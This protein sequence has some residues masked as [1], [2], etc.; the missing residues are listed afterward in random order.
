MDVT[1][2]LEAGM[3]MNLFTIYRNRIRWSLT[4]CALL[5][6][7]PTKRKESRN[8]RS[9]ERVSRRDGRGFKKTFEV[10]L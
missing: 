6:I 10:A 8:E 4:I 2:S 5:A 3:G 7:S 1:L 9:T